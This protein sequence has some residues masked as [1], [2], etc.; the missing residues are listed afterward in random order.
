MARLHDDETNKL[1]SELVVERAKKA[2]SEN[3]HDEIASDVL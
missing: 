1:Q 3:V 2:I